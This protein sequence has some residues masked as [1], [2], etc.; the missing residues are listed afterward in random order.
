MNLGSTCATCDAIEKI[1]DYQLQSSKN[2]NNCE[3][4]LSNDMQMS[5]SNKKINKSKA[6]NIF[7][8]KKLYQFKNNFINIIKLFENDLNN[9]N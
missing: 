9:V 1:S 6:R 8:N 5:E 7:N 2:D 4:I 3:K